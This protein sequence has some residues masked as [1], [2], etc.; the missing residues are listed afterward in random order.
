VNSTQDM[1]YSLLFLLICV[2][3]FNGLVIK[4]RIQVDSISA[5]NSELGKFIV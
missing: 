4:Q 5:I 2:S 1:L 3:L